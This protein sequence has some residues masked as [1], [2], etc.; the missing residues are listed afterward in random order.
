MYATRR[1]SA[2]CRAA[3]HAR[4][5]SSYIGAASHSYAQGPSVL[6]LPQINN[7]PNL[8]YPPGS[9]DRQKLSDAINKLLK[10]PPKEIPCLVGGKEIK[11]GLIG[12][13]RAPAQHAQVVST[14]HAADEQTTKLA[15]ENSLKAKKQWE[16]LP[17][18]AK[19]AIFLKAADL[20]A[21]PK[22][23]FEMLAS[24]MIGQGK[25]AWQSEIDCITE[26][27]DFW[28]F[29]VQYASQIFELQPK[30][31]SQY[32]W[33]HVEYRALEGFVLAITPFNFTAIGG[34]LPSSPAI[35]GNVALWKPSNTAL[36]SNYIVHKIL[37]EAGL[38][39]G[40]INF[41]PGDGLAVGKVA[42]NHPELAALHFTGSTATFQ[43]LWKT[44]GENLTTYKSYPRLVGE[45]GGKNFHFVHSSA[46]V[47][48]VLFHTI[49]SAFE[50]SGQ[51]C[52]A[53]SRLYIPQSLWIKG[54]LKEKM[55]STVQ[56]IIKTRMGLPQNF[57][58]FVS[59]VIDQNSFNKITRYIAQAKKDD[60]ST[61]GKLAKVIAGGG[62]DNKTGWF[63]EPTIIETT[64]PNYA[65]MREEL[66][67]PVLTVYVYEDSQ[68]EQMLDVCDQ[69]SPYSLTGSIFAND[70]YAL[71]L[72]SSKLRHSSG[73]FYINDKSTGAVVGQ[74][75]FGGGRGSGTNDKA[76]AIQNLIRWT[77][78]RAIK[79]NFMPLTTYLYPSNL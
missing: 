22:Y 49:R 60:E 29:N 58:T 42:F 57:N 53:C 70:R 76:G 73:N 31:H 45:T 19:A 10:S 15:I 55:I 13:Q 41:L 44:V 32:V 46:D 71:E 27:A 61:G 12:E 62:S 69:T 77:S 74:Q 34:N 59:A 48:Q 1:V 21:S 7:E 8:T 43:K 6:N 67:G 68:F 56:D 24:N 47:D 2:I 63:I 30:H 16:A 38:P 11:T 35:M 39:E 3:S 79:E 50:Y 14:F 9:P 51:K 75:P 18:S 40:V 54:G 78:P 23:R 28:R 52:S 65:T 25:N 37:L 33:N 64:D 4:C 20:L 36:L 66:F 5:F 17:F 26:L 72:A